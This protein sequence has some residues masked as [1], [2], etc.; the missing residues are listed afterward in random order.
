MVAFFMGSKTTFNL[1]EPAETIKTMPLMFLVNILPTSIVCKLPR[2]L[3]IKN[4]RTIILVA[5]KS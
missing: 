3:F 2:L 1:C 4:I 5:L